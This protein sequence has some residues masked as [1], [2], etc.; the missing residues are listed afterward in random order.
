MSKNTKFSIVCDIAIIAVGILAFTI[1]N[2]FLII[3]A[4]GTIAVIVAL[5]VMG[6][7]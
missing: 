6:K 7:D 1:R 3:A 5:F 2:F 4:M